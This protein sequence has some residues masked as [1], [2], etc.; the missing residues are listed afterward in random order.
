[1]PCLVDINGGPALFLT[2]MEWIAKCKEGMGQRKRR[3]GRL[4][5]RCK[6]NK[7]IKAKKNIQHL[8]IKYQ[9]ISF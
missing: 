4:M 7:Y 6:I 2:E 3:E 8:P 5:S 9:G 1:M